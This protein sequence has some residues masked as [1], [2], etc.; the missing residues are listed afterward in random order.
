[1][2]ATWRCPNSDACSGMSAPGSLACGD[3]YASPS[4]ACAECASGYGMTSHDPFQ[5]TRC[6]DDPGLSIAFFVAMN[7]VLLVINVD[8]ARTAVTEHKSDFA[9]VLKI[10][11]SWAALN[12]AMVRVDWEW[13]DIVGGFFGVSSVA[14]G[15]A[16]AVS[17]SLDSYFLSVT[18]TLLPMVSCRFPAPWTVTTSS[19]R[20]Q[21]W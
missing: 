5:C 15:H 6:P 14:A 7:V 3:G 16:P 9:S 1:M 17:S 18:N 12:S 20:L 8:A 4:L 11:M 21:H 13:R 10:I 19:T 2:W